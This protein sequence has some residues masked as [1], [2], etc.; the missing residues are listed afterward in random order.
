VID[1]G[2]APTP[3]VPASERPP[4]TTVDVAAPTG[5]P[6]T[7]AALRLFAWASRAAW[8]KATGRWDAEANARAVRQLLE[9]LG[10]I[11]IKV[12]QLLSLRIDVFS[13]ELCRELAHLQDAVQGFPPPVAIRIV[14]EELGAPIAR[15]FDVFDERPIAAAS[16]GQV[17]RARLRHEDAWVAVKVRRPHVEQVFEAQVAVVRRWS[18]ALD[19][20]GVLPFV[21]WR[22]VAWEVERI[23]R[24]ET[25]YRVEAAAIARM[26]RSLAPH[27]MYVPRPYPE[28]CTRR[29]LVMELVVGVQ[30]SDYIA[31]ARAD[32]AR[33]RAWERDNDVDA[34]LVVRRFS[35]SILRQ[36]VEDNLFHGDLH[37]GNVVLL[38][39]SRVALLDFG[40]VGVTDR[41]FLA[42][43]R[44]FMEAIA[45]DELEK[46]ADMALMLAG[47]LPRGGAVA[48]ARREV[49]RE[50]R[51]WRARTSVESLPYPVKSVDALNVAITKVFF[52]HR[53]TF[54]WAFLRIRRALA[55]MDATAQHL[56]PAADY[57]RI[58]RAYV[59]AAARRRLRARLGSSGASGAGSL[60]MPD[61]L[62]ASAALMVE[63]QRRQIR[64]F[65]KTADRTAVLVRTAARAVTIGLSA[66]AAVVA[67]LAATRQPSWASGVDLQVWLLVLGLAG[68][69]AAT[70]AGV[71]TAFSSRVRAPSTRS[72]AFAGVDGTRAS[73]TG[74]PVSR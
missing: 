15:V 6:G 16:I 32:P 14:E 74:S 1:P 69:G 24:E 63:I 3:L 51:A 50:I 72:A 61:Q 19:A 37:P 39:H 12:G 57:P 56:Y 18:R 53:I 30:M 13:E 45:L 58:T 54:D 36:I 73:R 49:V 21:E 10:G 9:R 42:R 27:E 71:A 41:E 20:L 29:V 47:P 64:V 59:R 23:V 40:T 35:Q 44:A 8:L 7:R 43:F 22:Q 25:D 66:T 38:R 2:L 5:F 4:V 55:T 62:V 26:R 33:V 46:A 60:D 48:L 52:R 17:H 70:A 67:V 31:A 65:G 28:Y 68:V 11:W 34:A